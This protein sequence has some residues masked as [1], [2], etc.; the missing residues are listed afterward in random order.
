M[1]DRFACVMCINLLQTALPILQAVKAQPAR[2]SIC[3][4]QAE[5]SSPP[6]KSSPKKLPFAGLMSRA[7]PSAPQPKDTSP[8]APLPKKGKLFSSFQLLSRSAS[9]A[10]VQ[11]KQA[12]HKANLA[13]TSQSSS[14]HSAAASGVG[15]DKV[16]GSANTQSPNSEV[17]WR[18][19]STTQDGE[20]DDDDSEVQPK[21]KPELS[22]GCLDE[23]KEGRYR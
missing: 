6:Q 12:G 11:P 21:R 15:Q 17:V 14:S 10:S 22:Q 3:S 8:R 9:A 5:T 7:K 23:L 19:P 4:P 1:C 13:F 20:A 2:K 16:L 18:R